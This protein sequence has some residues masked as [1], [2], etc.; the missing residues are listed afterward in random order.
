M[1]I[2]AER[3][4]TAV[5]ARQEIACCVMA[6][7]EDCATLPRSAR[8]EVDHRCGGPGGLPALTRSVSRFRAL[9]NGR[10]RAISGRG[11]ASAAVFNEAEVVLDRHPVELRGRAD[12]T[13]VWQPN[14]NVTG[15]VG[16]GAS[17]EPQGP[18]TGKRIERP[19]LRLRICRLDQCQVL[20][21]VD[22]RR[23]LAQVLETYPTE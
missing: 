18:V 15:Q 23:F 14:Q 22:L 3:R 11:F 10:L 8:F 7:V 1:F 4:T 17:G 9:A 6:P 13:P 12:A 21:P 5:A 2:P 19:Q 16:P 20:R